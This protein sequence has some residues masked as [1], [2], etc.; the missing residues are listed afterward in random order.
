MKPEGFGWNVTTLA[1]MVGIIGLILAWYIFREQRQVQ[2]SVNAVQRSVQQLAPVVA[3]TSP[4]DGDV[5]SAV[6]PV[7]GLTRFVDRNLYLIVTPDNDTPWVQKGPLRLY[8][9]GIWSGFARFGDAGRG[10]GQA[11]TLYCVATKSTLAEGRLE[12][13]PPDAVK[14][15]TITV[16]RRK[17]P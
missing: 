14:S 12:S 11:F 8:A 2:G 3:V 6:E 13:L 5:V 4:R 10:D 16:R 15:G 1:L 7:S 9:G 17:T